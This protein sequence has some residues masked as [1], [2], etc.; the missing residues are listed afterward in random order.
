[1][2]PVCLHL[3]LPPSL[4]LRPA[5]PHGLLRGGLLPLLCCLGDGLGFRLGRRR[6]LLGVDLVLELLVQRELGPD[7]GFGR[8]VA[9][10]KRCRIA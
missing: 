7:L 6:R 5:L 4:L 3:A 1:V 2:P 9:S 8:I 10:E